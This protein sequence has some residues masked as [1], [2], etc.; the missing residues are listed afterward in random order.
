MADAT[1]MNVKIAAPSV[2]SC[3][4][5]LCAFCLLLLMPALLLAY[6]G[7]GWLDLDW[8]SKASAVA[9]VTAPLPLAFGAFFAWKAAKERNRRN[10]LIAA[11]SALFVI[12][13]YVVIWA[14]GG[15]MLI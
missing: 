5:L 4:T 8:P 9:M 14:W 15:R 12:P 10:L 11:A 3:A 2:R 1:V 7:A 6:A 13:L